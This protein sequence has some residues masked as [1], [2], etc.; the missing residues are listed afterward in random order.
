MNAVP[1]R[2]SPNRP[3][4]P[5]ARGISASA[6]GQKWAALTE[7]GEVV[8]ALAGLD[9][10]RSTHEQRNFL[11]LIRDTEPWRREMAENGVADLAAVLEPG[12]TA[13]LAVTARG[14][15]PAPAALALW[16]EFA[17]ARAAILAL[18]PPAAARGPDAPT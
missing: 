5:P 6:V 10:E 9:P 17:D 1:P 8:A 14:A 3:M 18:L 13:L 15:D 7:A 16:R 12:I 2:F 11:A 4:V